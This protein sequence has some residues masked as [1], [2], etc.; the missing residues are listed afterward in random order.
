M[1]AACRVRLR[2]SRSHECAL[3]ETHQTTF[4]RERVR[5]HVLNTF[6]GLKYGPEMV[7]SG[8]DISDMATW[9]VRMN[10]RH[11]KN[12]GRRYVKQRNSCR[13]SDVTPWFSYISCMH[14]DTRFFVSSAE[15]GA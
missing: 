15:L 4:Q 14:L 1:F 6:T 13:L 12:Y 8:S 10:R 2:R 7:F 9:F 5:G 11:S 3:R